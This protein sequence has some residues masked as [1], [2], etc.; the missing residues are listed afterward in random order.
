MAGFS[1]DR[2]RELY[3]I[4][5][6]F[7]PVAVLAIGHPGVPADLLEVLRERELAERSRHPQR[8][9]VF[10]TTWGDPLP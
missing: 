5:D 2:A 7:E 3:A 1:T 6:G 10:S 9:F 8:A 4:P